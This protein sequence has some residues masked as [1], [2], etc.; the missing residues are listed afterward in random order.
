MEQYKRVYCSGFMD[1]RC[2][3][4]SS[5]FL[6]SA[7]QIILGS[8][9][10]W[11]NVVH[12]HLGRIKANSWVISVIMGVHVLGKLDKQWKWWQM[13]RHV[14][15]MDRND[16]CCTAAKQNWKTWTRRYKETLDQIHDKTNWDN[17]QGRTSVFYFI[18]MYPVFEILRMKIISCLLTEYSFVHIFFFYYVVLLLVQ[19]VIFCLSPLVEWEFIVA[20]YACTIHAV[21]KWRS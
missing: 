12:N 3:L 2:I 7:R 20:V 14:G 4:L 11:H 21:T 6:V 10:I 1:I 15:S 9:D 19:V 16:Q 17:K 5:Q 8:G 13:V 18:I